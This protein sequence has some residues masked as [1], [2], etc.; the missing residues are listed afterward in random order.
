MRDVIPRK[1]QTH[2]RIETEAGGAAQW[3]CPNIIWDNRRCDGREGEHGAVEDKE[4]E[5]R[6]SGKPPTPRAHK[7]KEKRRKSRAGLRI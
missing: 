1:Q 7:W 5:R 6:R 2:T 4:K 3:I